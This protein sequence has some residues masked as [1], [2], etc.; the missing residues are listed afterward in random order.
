MFTRVSLTGII[1]SYVAAFLDARMKYPQS[2]YHQQLL[3]QK[4]LK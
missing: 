1:C 2:Y 4:L 3:W